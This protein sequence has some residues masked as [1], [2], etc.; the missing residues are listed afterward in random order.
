MEFRIQYFAVCIRL[1]MP[2]SYFTFTISININHFRS[3]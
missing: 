1:Y 3:I 2:C